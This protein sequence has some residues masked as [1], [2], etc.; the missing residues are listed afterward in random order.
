MLYTVNTKSI[1]HDNLYKKFKGGDHPH[2]PCNNHA[3]IPSPDPSLRTTMVPSHPPGPSCE[4]PPSHPTP[5]SIPTNYHGPIPLYHSLLL[6]VICS[7]NI[8][9]NFPISHPITNVLIFNHSII[10][11]FY[12]MAN[13]IEIIFLGTTSLTL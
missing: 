1:I 2:T 7:L 5:R 13:A 11:T 10:A 3:P 9:I 8:R 6:H 12:S 4:L